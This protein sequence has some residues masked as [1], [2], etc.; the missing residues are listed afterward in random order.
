MPEHYQALE[1]PN[2]ERTVEQS[3]FMSYTSHLERELILCANELAGPP[4]TALDFGCEAG[5]YSQILSERGWLM[6]CADTNAAALELCQQRI[7]GARCVPLTEANRE[8]PCPDGNLG[9]L[10]CI[11][12]PVMPAQWFAAEATRA[13]RIGGAL[14]GVFHN[15]LSWRGVVQHVHASLTGCHDWYSNS[16]ASWR[17]MMR[18]RGFEMVR[19]LGWRWPPFALTSNSPLLSLALRAE[20]AMGLQKLVAVSPMVG[21]VAIKQDV[22]VHT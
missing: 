21:F 11:E 9:I 5:R 2:W 20:R 17:R 19:E 18:L 4:T 16:Y 22:T 13:L 8:I 12:C 3:R 7:P 15:K 10:L 1:L 6:I 14:V